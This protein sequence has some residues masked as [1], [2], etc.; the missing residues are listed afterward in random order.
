MTNNEPDA[1]D[2]LISLLAAHRDANDDFD[3]IDTVLSMKPLLISDAYERLCVAFDMCPLHDQDLD[4]CRDDDA[5]EIDDYDPPLS[6]CRT[7]R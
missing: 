7:L 3:V 2:N 1:T 4:S 5:C 6:A